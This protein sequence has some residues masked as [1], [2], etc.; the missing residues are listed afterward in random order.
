MPRP[1]HA[2]LWI[3][4]ALSLAAGG[5]GYS[6]DQWQAQLAK[7]N[8]LKAD[9]DEKTG[10][11]AEAQKKVDDLTKELQALGVNV[12]SMKADLLERDKALESYKERAR[13]LELIKARFEKLKAKLD[14]LTKLGLAVNVRHN[15]M[16]ISLP[17]DV[18]FDSG[19]ETLKKEGK[20]IL[21]KV[22]GIIKADPQLVSRDYQVAGDT[23]N[24]PLAHGPFK[25]NWGLSLMRAREVLVFLI[26]PGQGGLPV[27]HW[28]AAGFGDSDP[29]AD[30]AT[31]DGRQKNRRC[32]LI[33]LPS[34][35]EMLDLKAIT[36]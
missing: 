28:S 15:R 36:Q 23:D 6:E 22:A 31:P 18:L 3:G 14:E 21:L 13:Q 1:L 8:K 4:L 25:D 32:E 19:K 7:Y 16:V 5:C 27:P 34:V 2:P 12:S 30:N 29:V 24:Q 26:D 17:G 10:Q 35:E 20:D 33:V 11:L 9:D